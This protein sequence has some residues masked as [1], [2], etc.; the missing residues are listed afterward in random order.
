MDEKLNW[1][2][3]FIHWR[4]KHITDKHPEEAAV[5]TERALIA[6]SKALKK[7][8]DNIEKAEETTEKANKIIIE[9]LNKLNN[10]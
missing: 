2:Q 4:E 7:G 3:R 1:F 9:Q 10:R 5:Q 8:R 6:F